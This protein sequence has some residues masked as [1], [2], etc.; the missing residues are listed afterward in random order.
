MI[1]KIN[2]YRINIKNNR[3]NQNNIKRELFELR[4]KEEILLKEFGELVYLHNNLENKKFEQENQHIL[5]LD[6][7]KY[8][9]ID[10]QIILALFDNGTIGVGDKLIKKSLVLAELEEQGVKEDDYVTL[11]RRLKKQKL[12]IFDMGYY[13]NCRLENLVKNIS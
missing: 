3:D 7:K 10:S 1:K 11:L 2:E 4:I 12:V 9:Y 13:S 8:D 6:L 5:I